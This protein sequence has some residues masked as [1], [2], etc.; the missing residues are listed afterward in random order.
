MA[1]GTSCCRVYMAAHYCAIVV[2]KPEHIMILVL[3][4][5]LFLPEFPIILFLICSQ[6]ITYYSYIIL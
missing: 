1:M 3:P 2:T 5:L 6:G 4:A